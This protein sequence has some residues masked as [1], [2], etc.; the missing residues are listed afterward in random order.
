ML[1]PVEIPAVDLGRLRRAIQQD[2][3][4][5]AMEPEDWHLALAALSC[6]L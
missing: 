1:R 6:S 3:T 2:Y 5:M 4:A